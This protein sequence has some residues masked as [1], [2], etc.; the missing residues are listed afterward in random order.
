MYG[1]L[2]ININTNIKGFKKIYY[3]PFMTL[4]GAPSNAIIYF[5]ENIVITNEDLGGKTSGKVISIKTF[6][7]SKCSDTEQP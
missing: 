5:P 2:T 1:I 3:K 4:K 6:K 7:K